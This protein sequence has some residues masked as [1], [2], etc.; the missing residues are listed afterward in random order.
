M[1]QPPSRNRRVL[2]KMIRHQFSPSSRTYILCHLLL[3]TVGFAI[4]LTPWAT[5]DTIV[6][7][8]VLAVGGSLIAAGIAGNALYLHVTW[9]QKE[10][11]R[12]EEIRRAGIERVFEKR[13]VAM[14]SEYDSRLE[15]ASDSIDILGFG[16]QHLREDHLEHFPNWADRAHVRILVIDPE[17]P[18]SCSPY[19]D[20]RDREEGSDLGQ[21][22]QDVRTLVSSCRDLLANSSGRFEIRLYT[23]LPSVNVFRIDDE[24]FWGPYFVGGVSRNMP[25]FLLDG[26]GFVSEAIMAHFDRIWT[27]A[28]LSREIPPEWLAR[29]E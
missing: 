8:V 14:R 18:S 17:S 15:R 2:Q 25:T 21:I 1:A 22:A 29:S 23:C 19:A 9:S 7:S 6:G 4:C 28:D 27:D 13:S 26:R 16:L 20:Q 5:P 11:G 10:E 12:L 24:V 3:L